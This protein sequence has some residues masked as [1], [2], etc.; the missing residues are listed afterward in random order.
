MKPDDVKTSRTGKIIVAAILLGFACMEFPG[1]LFFSDKVHPYIF[2]LPF[3]YG[4]NILWW[5]YFCVV[6]LAAAFLDWGG[7]K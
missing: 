2:G 6:L 7:L 4:W 5:V 3:I 1:V